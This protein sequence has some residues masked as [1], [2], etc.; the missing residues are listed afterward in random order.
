MTMLVVDAFW[1]KKLGRRSIRLYKK[2]ND[3]QFLTAVKEEWQQ[4]VW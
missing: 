1:A 4:F 3:Q 2:I